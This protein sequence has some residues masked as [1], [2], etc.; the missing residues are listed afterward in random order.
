MGSPADLEELQATSSTTSP[1]SS[2]DLSDISA[3]S[4]LG[5]VIAQ[6]Q[7]FVIKTPVAESKCCDVVEVS[8]DD[9][10]A[11]VAYTPNEPESKP[12]SVKDVLAE[13]KQRRLQGELMKQSKPCTLSNP[14]GPLKDANSDAGTEN[15]YVLPD[16]VAW[17]CKLTFNFWCCL[18]SCFHELLLNP[19]RNN[20]MNSQPILSRLV[21]HNLRFWRPFDPWRYLHPFLQRTSTSRPCKL[22]GTRLQF[23][24]RRMKSWQ[25]ILPKNA[26]MKVLSHGTTMQLEA[27]GLISVGL[28]RVFL[29]K[30]PK[31][32]GRPVMPNATI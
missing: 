15:P 22:L 27:N 7:K 17:H 26:N 11:T 4:K 16:H 25:L 31:A 9:D 2:A 24:Q 29:S 18:I 30:R 28:T 14:K 5:R 10:S 13:A 32:C 3:D 8:S 12:K 21:S 6:L 19:V 20:H 23:H 1:G